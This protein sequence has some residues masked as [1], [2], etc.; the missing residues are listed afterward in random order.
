MPAVAYLR[1]SRV[2]TRRPGDLSHEQQLAAV[3][4]LAEQHGDDPDELLVIE[5]WGATGWRPSY[6]QETNGRRTSKRAGMAQ[7]EAMLDRRE[8][9]AIYT[10]STTRLARSL[11]VLTRLVNRCAAAEV[12]IRCADGHSPDVSS[13]NGR[14]MVSILGSVAAWQAEWTAERMQEVTTMRRGRGDHLGPAPFGYRVVDGQVVSN[15]AEKIDAVLDAF[16][17]AGSYQAAAR[18]LTARRVRTRRG[19]DWTATTVRSVITRQ[20]PELVPSTMKRGRRPTR[21]FRLTGLLRCTCG[22]NLTGR[23]GRRGFVAYECRRAARMLDHPRPTSVAEAKVLPWIQA[24][25]ARLQPGPEAVAIEG[26]RAAREELEARRQ[27]VIDNYEDGL[28]RGGKDERD[29]KLAAIAGE[30]EALGAVRRVVEDVEPVDWTW[31]NE[32]VNRV[33]RAL[34]DRVELDEQLRPVRAE[35]LVPEWRAA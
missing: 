20:A 33:L 3:R 24:E 8:V 6:G 16:R 21:S 27:R 12:P 22:W 25:A 32:D 10:Y 26:D 17:E 13:A 30:L 4:R 31:G 35:W 7:L 34:W 9:T 2:D 5:D 15:P 1:R 28:L 14:L 19:E 11:E 18:L 23:T 29:R